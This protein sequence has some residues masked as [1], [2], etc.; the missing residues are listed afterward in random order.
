[1]GFSPKGIEKRGES[2]PGEKVSE[3]VSEFIGI[4]ILTVEVPELKLVC[5]TS[6]AVSKSPTKKQKILLKLEALGYSHISK[7]SFFLYLRTCRGK[8]ELQ[9]LEQ[10]L[11]E[12]SLLK[13]SHSTTIDIKETTELD[14]NN[15]LLNK[16]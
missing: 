7:D 16:W 13:E 10:H 8:D 6:T 2:S 5:I 4:E 9:I 14:F 12:N 15:L 11:H 3:S 1:M